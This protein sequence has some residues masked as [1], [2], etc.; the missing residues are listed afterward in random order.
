MCH[1]A[2][3]GGGLLGIYCLVRSRGHR[4]WPCQKPG[5]QATSRPLAPPR[6][7]GQHP[8]VGWRS[9]SPFLFLQ[10]FAINHRGRRPCPILPPPSFLHQVLPRAPLFLFQSFSL[11]IL[12]NYHPSVST[13]KQTTKPLHPLFSRLPATRS[14]SRPQWPNPSRT[15]GLNSPSLRRFHLQSSPRR[16]I[17]TIKENRTQANMQKPQHPSEHP[18]QQCSHL[19]ACSA[20]WC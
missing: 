16:A 3:L 4:V 6:C 9:D 2:G 5:A 8:K 1:L 17:T 12:Y 11:R 10:K 18:R 14:Q 15:S 7:P 13:T 20:A 19:I